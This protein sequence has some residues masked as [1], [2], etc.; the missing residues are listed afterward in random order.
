MRLSKPNFMPT[1]LLLIFGLTIVL[2]PNYENKPSA[3]CTYSLPGWIQRDLADGYRNLG[4][5]LRWMVVLNH[6]GKWLLENT[7]PDFFWLA[8]ELD[9]ITRWN[10]RAAHAYYMAAT[11]LPWHTRNTLLSRPLLERAMSAIPGD[12]RWPYY[13]GFNAYWFDDDEDTAVRFL[14]LAANLPDAPPIVASLAA[15]MEAHKGRLETALRFLENLL[16]SKQERAIRAQIEARIVELQTEIALRRVEE[17]L[18][19]L[20][21]SAADPEI[22]RAKGVRLPYVLPDGGHIVFRN[23]RLVSSK[24][25]KRFELYRSPHKPTGHLRENR[26]QHGFDS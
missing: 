24:T 26:S 5:I 3:S 20:G 13:R 23:D 18:H 10:P 25:G 6:F 12:W 15:R 19:K 7:P 16:K 22:L 2:S 9:I 8:K 21:I 4:A 17:Q 1:L 11:V 14:R